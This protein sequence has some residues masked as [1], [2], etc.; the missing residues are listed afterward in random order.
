VKFIAVAT[1]Q[2][3]NLNFQI[4]EVIKCAGCES[5]VILKFKRVVYR[6]GIKWS[7]VS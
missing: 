5:A 6:H 4:S 1:N 7:S 2:H 3:I